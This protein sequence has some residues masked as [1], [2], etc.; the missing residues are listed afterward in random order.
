MNDDPLEYLFKLESAINSEISD[1]NLI[2]E[3][4][5][6]KVSP[7]G[8]IHFR[9]VFLSL[10]E[11]ATEALEEKIEEELALNPDDFDQAKFDEQFLDIISDF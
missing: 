6:L 10:E 4:D 7:S 11:S 3:P 2:V 5:S 1:L 9:I 8:E